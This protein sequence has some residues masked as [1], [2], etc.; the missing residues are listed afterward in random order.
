MKKSRDLSGPLA[1]LKVIELAGIGPAPLCAMLLADMGADVIR[2]DRTRPS[3]LGSPRPAKFD[4]TRRNRPSVAVDLKKKEGVETV[5]KLVEQADALIDPFRPGVAEK[6]G[7]GPNDCFARNARLVFARMTGW[8]QSGPMSQTAGHD[9]NYLAI[10][11]VLN[12]IGTREKPI[13]PLNIAADMGGGAMFLAFGIMAAVFEARQSQKGQEVDVCMSEGAAYLAAGN[14]ASLA[15][16]VWSDQREDNLLD[17]GAPFYRTYQTKDD[18]WVSIGPIEAKFYRIVIEKL[19]LEGESLPDQF[20]KPNWPELHDR[21]ESVFKT[22]TQAEW[23]KVFEGTDACFAPVIS[24]GEAA[25]HHHNKARS[26]FVE[27]DGVVQPAPTPKF[28]RTPAATPD[29]IPGIGDDTESGLKDWGFSDKEVQ[30]LMKK[31][32]IGGYN[33]K[34]GS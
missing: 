19:G 29:G 22:R 18:R 31:E 34:E 33:E 1:G 17:G 27:I 11:G 15:A 13:P 21:F 25:E 3:G 2:I 12:A 26:S 28:S 23:C 6:L 14:F 8:G 5:M 4:V 32:A 24:F 9:I 20:D 16:G 30:D 7:L 10:S